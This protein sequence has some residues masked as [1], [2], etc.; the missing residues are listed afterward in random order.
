MVMKVLF[1]CKVTESSPKKVA[2]LAFQKGKLPNTFNYTIKSTRHFKNTEIFV[3]SPEIKENLLHSENIK[4]V[5]DKNMTSFYEKRFAECLGME[6]D[7]K[8]KTR[9]KNVLDKLPY[10]VAS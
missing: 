6:E 7:M 10:G 4:F 1:N 2:L 3:F 8:V 9:L 5:V